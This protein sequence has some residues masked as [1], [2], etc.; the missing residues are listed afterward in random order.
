MACARVSLGPGFLMKLLG[1]IKAFLDF[2]QVAVDLIPKALAPEA[3]QLGQ[4]N[5]LCIVGY[6]KD[7][8]I[9][10]GEFIVLFSGHL[11]LSFRRQD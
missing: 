10:L 5:Q 1:L 4:F 2:A 3:L 8:L 7:I 6:G 9:E 11:S